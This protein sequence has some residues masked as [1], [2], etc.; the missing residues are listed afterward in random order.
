MYLIVSPFIIARKALPP[1]LVKVPCNG[2]K[3]KSPDCRVL[4]LCDQIAVGKTTEADVLVKDVVHP[5]RETSASSL[6]NLLWIDAS[7]MN[8]SKSS[9]SDAVAAVWV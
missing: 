5:T 2:E 7:T 1:H 8:R 3:E 4:I 6:S 9:G